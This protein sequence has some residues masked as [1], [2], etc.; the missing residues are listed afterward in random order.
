M[1]FSLYFYVVLSLIEKISG[2]RGRGTIIGLLRGG[3]RRSIYSLKT[4]SEIALDERYSGIMAKV[5]NNKILAIFD[6]LLKGGLIE[7]VEDN[8]KGQWFPLVYMT[9]KGRETLKEKEPEF[10][11]KLENILGANRILVEFQAG[12]SPAEKPSQS[13][14]EKDVK[15]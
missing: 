4:N 11:P 5:P 6:E 9:G 7:I 10:L 14:G 8:F 13:G 15:E 3:K 1:N 2:K 12:L